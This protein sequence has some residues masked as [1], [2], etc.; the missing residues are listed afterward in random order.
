M[1]RRASSKAQPPLRSHKGQVASI[2]SVATNNVSYG[3]Q[4][5]FLLELLHFAG[6]KVRIRRGQLTRIRAARSGV[7]LDVTGASLGEAAG[8]IF[9]RAMRTSRDAGPSGV[10]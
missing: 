3:G 8:T 10:T 9:A 7:E 2:R 1:S 4:E 5:S 6:W